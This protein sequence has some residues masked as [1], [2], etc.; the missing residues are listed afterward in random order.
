MGGIMKL[1]VRCECGKVTGTIEAR[2]LSVH[3]TCY[4]LDCQAFARHLGRPERMLDAHGGTEVIGTLPCR[5][6]FHTGADQLA[7]ITLTPRGPLRWYAQCCRSSLGN[8]S[9]AP[10]NPF[11][12]LHCHAIDASPEQIRRAFG[13]ESFRFAVHAASAAV[14]AKR[15]GF[16][17]AIPKILWNIVYAKI[18]GAWRVNPF[19]K[20]GTDE[21][22]R[23]P[24]ELTKEQRYALRGDSPPA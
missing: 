19:F 3:G 8:G 9:R 23:A 12:T 1:P 7:C 10:R 14:P 22:L 13:P 6:T 16:L 20:P 5:L 4:C 21:P 18:S 11:V 2:G 15:A 24:L 17:I